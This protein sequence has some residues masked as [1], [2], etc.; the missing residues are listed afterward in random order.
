MKIFTLK[1]LGYMEFA[2]TMDDLIGHL[3]AMLTMFYINIRSIFIVM[4][5]DVIYS[6]SWTV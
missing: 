6:Y 4:G 5:A 3:N 1:K 2:V